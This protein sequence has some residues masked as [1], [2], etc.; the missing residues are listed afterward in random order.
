MKTIL[1]FLAAE[2]GVKTV[3][4]SKKISLGS[5]TWVSSVRGLSLIVFR[6]IRSYTKVCM[7][8]VY[9][10]A[11]SKLWR[12]CFTLGKSLGSLFMIS[13]KKK[14]T[15]SMGVFNSWLTVAVKLSAWFALC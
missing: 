5:K 12:H 11:R 10:K 14:M 3:K 13:F 4:I 9:A 6:S 8:M 2:S 7:R 15:E 1:T